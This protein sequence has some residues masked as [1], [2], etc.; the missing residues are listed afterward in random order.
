MLPIATGADWRSA[1]LAIVLAA[2]ALSTIVLLARLSSKL[3]G[4]TVR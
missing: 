1:V 4:P 2:V 3:Q